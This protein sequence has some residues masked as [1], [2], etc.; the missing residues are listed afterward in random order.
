MTKQH[1][2]PAKVKLIFAEKALAE[3]KKKA[4]DAA[5]FIFPEEVLSATEAYEQSIGEKLQ[6]EETV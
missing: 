3:I 6:Q 2:M 5:L 1:D 4:T